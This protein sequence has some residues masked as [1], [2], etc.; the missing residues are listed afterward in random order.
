MEHRRVG[1]AVQGIVL[2]L[3]MKSSRD[4][5]GVVRR[6]CRSSSS[7]GAVCLRARRAKVVE[8]FAKNTG[9]V[10]MMLTPSALS[11]CS[12]RWLLAAQG[13]SAAHER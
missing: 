10:H 4:R 12:G 5:W 1:A 11:E 7:L 9:V 8:L 2:A 13:R 6:L 3:V